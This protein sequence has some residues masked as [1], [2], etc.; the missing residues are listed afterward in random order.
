MFNSLPHNPLTTL[1]EEAFENIVG[2]GQNAGNQHFFPFPTRFS[3]LSE[4]EIS[5]SLTSTMLSA[6]AF[7]LDQSKIL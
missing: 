2:K 7:N 4:R 6:N 5:I 3:T 1:K